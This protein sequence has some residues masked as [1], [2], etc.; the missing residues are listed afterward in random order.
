VLSIKDIESHIEQQVQ[1]K[2][3]PGFALS[4]I[5]ETE[6]LY[7]KAFG[8][9][10]WEESNQKVTTDTLFRVGSV[11]KSLT[12]TLIMKLVEEGILDLDVPIC[13]YIEEFTRIRSHHNSSYVAKSYR[14]FT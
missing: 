6:I 14:G 8:L 5:N 12:G 7:E 11:S 4:I 1:N 13:T 3:V 2:T 10:N 9:M